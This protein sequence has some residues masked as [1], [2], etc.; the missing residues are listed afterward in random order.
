MDALAHIH[1]QSD[2]KTPIRNLIDSYVNH[3]NQR[4]QLSAI[5]A[6]GTLGDR[7]SQAVLQTLAGDDRS[8]R[9]ASVAKEALQSLQE[10]TPPVP[11]E[12]V[13]L[14]KLLTQ[15]QT[16][17]DKLREDVD[18]LKKTIEADPALDTAEVDGDTQSPPTAVSK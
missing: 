4:I 12:I 16:Q 1:R 8:D 14:R 9:I 2:N 10:K 11:A 13:Q 7:R 3:P 17:N 6:L 5:R 15:M 18:Q